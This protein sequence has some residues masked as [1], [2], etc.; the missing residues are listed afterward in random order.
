VSD[1]P[2]VGTWRLVSFEVRD[3]EGQSPAPSAGMLSASS[4]TRRV[5]TL[6]LF[7]ASSQVGRIPELSA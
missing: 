1:D 2:L 3:E 4:A 6:G 5:R 7:G